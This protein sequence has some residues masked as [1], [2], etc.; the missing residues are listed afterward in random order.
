MTC[1]FVQKN[2]AEYQ[3]CCSKNEGKHPQSLS[4]ISENEKKDSWGMGERACLLVKIRKDRKSYYCVWFWSPVYKTK[5]YIF[6]TYKWNTKKELTAKAPWNAYIRNPHQFDLHL[7][8]IEM[9]RPCLFAFC[10]SVKFFWTPCGVR[11]WGA[12]NKHR[13]SFFIH[14]S[15]FSVFRRGA[16]WPAAPFLQPSSAPR[17]PATGSRWSP[18][19]GRAGWVAV[20]WTGRS[21]GWRSPPPRHP[22]RPAT[23]VSGSSVAPSTPRR[24]DVPMPCVAAVM[25][26]WQMT[27]GLGKTGP[28]E[29]CVLGDRAFLG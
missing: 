13:W 21:G 5:R 1:H 19:W 4:R 28:G 10:C 9:I 15:V 22:N 29:G 8:K 2:E 26:V 11:F 17:Q 25:V 27:E 24:V 6:I 20:C 23:S 3:T 18:G 7:P 12:R 14:P 16:F